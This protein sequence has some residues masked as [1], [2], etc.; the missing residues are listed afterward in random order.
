MRENE[1][2][3]NMKFS[4][5]AIILPVLILSVSCKKNTAASSASHSGITGQWQWQYT[6]APGGTTY[7][8][9]DSTVQLVV[10][11]DS[12]NHTNTFALWLNDD[13]RASGT[14]QWQDTILVFTSSAAINNADYAQD[15]VFN[16][17]N[18]SEY[19]VKVSQDT[20]W[21]SKNFIIPGDTS[22]YQTPIE[23]QVSVFINRPNPGGISQPGN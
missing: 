17:T 7:P 23:P 13:E 2:T 3:M 11:S 12:V 22:P 14:W 4:H 16:S 20:L 5:L 6:T 9:P 1:S 19:F 8:L 10:A 21:L 15:I 18:P